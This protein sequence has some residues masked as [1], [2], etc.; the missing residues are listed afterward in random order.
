MMTR[1]VVSGYRRFVGTCC[2][3]PKSRG[4]RYKSSSLG[5]LR[6]SQVNLSELLDFWTSSFVPY[7]IKLENTTFGQLDLFPT[8]LGPL[9]RAN[10][11]HWIQLFIRDPKRVGVSHRPHLRTETDPVFETLPCLFFVEYRTM[12]KVQN[13]SNSECYSQS[14]EPFRISK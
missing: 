4:S 7:C 12:D 5:K 3:R 10:L 11:N 9:E 1:S 2:F 6:G 13:P 8:L 14:S